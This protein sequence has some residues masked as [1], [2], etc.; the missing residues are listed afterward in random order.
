MNDVDDEDKLTFNIFRLW[1]KMP[2]MEGIASV[3]MDRYD[4]IINAL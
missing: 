1:K 3:S 4:L 2:K